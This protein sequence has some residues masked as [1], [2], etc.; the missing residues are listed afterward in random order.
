[1][2]SPPPMNARQVGVEYQDPEQL[3]TC[4]LAMLSLTRHKDLQPAAEV[5]GQEAAGLQV[6]SFLGESSGTHRLPHLIPLPASP[7]SPIAISTPQPGFLLVP[8]Q[9]ATPPLLL[10]SSTLI[11]SEIY[12]AA[13]QPVSCPESFLWFIPFT[14][15]SQPRLCITPFSLFLASTLS[16]FQRPFQTHLFTFSV[17]LPS[18]SLFPFLQFHS[19]FPSPSRPWCMLF[20]S[21]V[22]PR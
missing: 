20:I 7:P 18:N 17:L 6:P 12:P 8:P 9:V 3:H 4:V 11:Y 22:R 15:L 1:M 5:H 19:L 13:G 21:G 14:D 16:C 2:A 10:N